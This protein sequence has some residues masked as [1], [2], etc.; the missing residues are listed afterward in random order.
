MTVNAIG[1]IKSEQ[2]LMQGIASL[3]FAQINYPSLVVFDSRVQDLDIL[4]NALVPG[5]IAYTIN[6]QDDALEVITRLLAVTGAKR[7]AIAAHGAP[8]VVHIGA[9]PLNGEQ[10]Q[11]RAALLQEWCV[12]EIALYSCEV[13]AE[14]QFIAE[15]EHLTGATVAAATGKVG[16][17]QQGGTW[18]LTNNKTTY[19]D[20]AKLVGYSEVLAITSETLNGI[21]SDGIINS[22]ET[23]FTIAGNA[24]S[25]GG[26]NNQG[27]KFLLAIYS[28]NTLLY[29]QIA[30]PASTSGTNATYS[31]S[32]NL[33]TILDS[34]INNYQN[35]LQFKVY[36][37]NGDNGSGSLNTTT[38]TSPSAPT[39]N[40]LRSGGQTTLTPSTTTGLFTPISSATLD[41]I[42]PTTPTIT[43]VADDVAPVIGTVANGGSTNDTVLV[44]NGTA[45]ANSTVTL[46]NGATQLGTATT[47]GSGNWTFTTATLTDGTTY[48]FTARSTDTAGNSS[49]SSAYSVTVDTTAPTAGTLSLTSFSDTGSSSSDS[50]TND[51]SFDLSLAGNESGANIAYEVSTDNG[52]TWTS[53][54]A[55]QTSLADGGYQFRAVVTDTAGNSSNSN[56]SSVLIDTVAPTVL[57]LALATDSG[58]SNSDSITNSGVVNVAGLESGA[59]WEY[60]TDNGSNWTAGTGTSFTLT[61]DGAKSAIARQTD[62]AGNTSANSTA[63]NFTLDTLAPTAPTINS[64]A[65][66][67][68]TTLRL[69]GTA[70][71]G[72]TVTISS[73]T[74]ALGTAV[75]NAGS[76]SFDTSSL[77]D[78][79]FSVT[80]KA[81]DV[82]GNTSPLSAASNIIAGNGSANTLNGTTNKDIL[83][84]YAGNDTLDGLNEDDILLGG[85]GADS[86]SGGNGGDIL[87]GG[88]GQDT[89]TGGNG[90]DR[91]DL[92]GTRTTGSDII[93]DFN[94]GQADTLLVSQ[95]DFG[96]LTTGVNNQLS[97]ALFATTTGS[98]NSGTRFIYNSTSGALFFDADGSGSGTALQI[99][100]LNNKPTL[101]ASNFEVIA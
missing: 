27:A 1:A 76:W 42:A 98:I 19:F 58:S 25:V 99:A 38:N 81:T 74:T 97:S 49:N 18:Q 66:V 79:T 82:A 101:S 36:Q 3:D 15:L 21:G 90:K 95:S 33:N 41:T 86:L 72:S 83:V 29:W 9:K 52:S 40:F 47:N 8:G 60:S 89:L 71:A 87:V 69:T 10:L 59:T 30:E 45:E 16:A 11:S 28:G 63:F 12:E 92:A 73:G 91:F 34:Q 44:L 56:T 37:G 13:G 46:F 20:T 94:G 78:G 96:P 5:A 68:D 31:F 67:S 2:S 32:V 55:A 77:V 84:G 50:I 100:Q 70:E 93:T 4:Y 43:S 7:L 35:S 62:V 57:S 48:S 26:S 75:S 61:G 53:T 24:N 14:H 80:T 54:T 22:S 23:N 88:S 64:Y 39:F 85:D 6:P 65:I 17:I 51:N